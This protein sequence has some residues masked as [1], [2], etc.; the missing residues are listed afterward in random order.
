M[1]SRVHR[2][3]ARENGSRKRLALSTDVGELV[4]HR[5]VGDAGTIPHAWWRASAV[6]LMGYLAAC[7]VPAE[8]PKGNGHGGATQNSSEVPAPLVPGESAWVEDLA[9]Q[10]GCPRRTAYIVGGSALLGGGRLSIPPAVVSVD[11]FCIDLRLVVRGEYETCLRQ[12]KCHRQAPLLQSALTSA[13]AEQ[14]C[15]RAGC[16]VESFEPIHCVTHQELEEF[17]ASRGGKLPSTTQ[18]EYAARASLVETKD[19][20]PAVRGL[21]DGTAEW[22]SEV[23]ADDLARP[24]IVAFRQAIIPSATKWFWTRGGGWED[25]PR[26]LRATNASLAAD[27]QRSLHIGGR[28]VFVPK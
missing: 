13:T 24:E 22:T 28:C 6:A 20:A 26:P 9:R 8:T 21:F 17:C 18:W 4:R 2:H 3:C 10:H 27:G 5:S 23:D 25:V 16:L 15:G 11:S 14:C 1:K 19:A 12:D 7:A